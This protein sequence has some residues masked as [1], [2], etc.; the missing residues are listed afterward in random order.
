MF[1]RKVRQTKFLTLK[2][3]TFESYRFNYKLFIYICCTE[4]SIWG[5]AIAIK[6]SIFTQLFLAEQPAVKLDRHFLESNGLLNGLFA[7]FPQP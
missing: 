6:P 5:Q 2:R 3:K 4:A 1:N 7:F